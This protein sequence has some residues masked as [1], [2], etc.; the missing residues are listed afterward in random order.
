MITSEPGSFYSVRF[1]LGEFSQQLLLLVNYGFMRFKLCS[2]IQLAIWVVL[3]T[4]VLLAACRTAPNTIPNP[5]PQDMAIATRTPTP[6]ATHPIPATT[7]SAAAVTIVPSLEPTAV[8]TSTPTPTPTPHPLY[9]YTIPALRIQAFS[10]GQI[11]T[12]AILEQ[13]EAFTRTYIDY[14]SDG[15]TITGM[16]HV[17]TGTGPFP[18]LILLHG[19]VDRDQ[20]YAGSDTSQAADYF[21]RR[22]Y[23]VLA[24][25]LR[26]WGES[27]SGLSLFHMGLVVDVLNLI[28]SLLSVPEADPARVGLWGHSMGGGIATKVLTIDER[29]KTAVLYAPN[30]ADDADL[31]ARWGPGCL[32]GQSEAA[33]DHCNPAEIIPPNTE[34]ELVEA[35]LAAAANPDFLRE[36]APLYHV[37]NITAPI[38]I[39]I[40]TADGEFL[41]ETPP[42]WSEKLATALQAANRDV[43][44]FTYP[45]QGHFFTGT[46]W[47]TL[48]DRALALFDEQLKPVAR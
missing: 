15:L 17:P 20:Y 13:N 37:A 19:Y 9:A 11:R 18:V 4:A 44:F 48:L 1:V 46:S 26:S 10:G 6:A 3:L 14:P 39:H 30:S 38:Q 42:E 45:D 43:A 32:P 5:T 34:P 12:R 29:V 33:G 22:G 36:V 35:Y 23:L 21:A 27:D 24:P 28:S 31:I 7:P 8:A 41:A 2:K 25:D 16:M 40:G 47:T